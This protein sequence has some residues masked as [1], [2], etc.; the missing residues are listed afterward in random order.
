[1]PKRKDPDP[2]PDEV[3]ATID[4]HPIRRVFTTGVVGMLGLILVYVAAATPP[5]IWNGWPFW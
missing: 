2:D 5:P 4:P 1:M 3:L